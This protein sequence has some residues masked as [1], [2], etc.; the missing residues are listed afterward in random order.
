MT[1]NNTTINLLD[2][3]QN[4][5]AENLVNHLRPF[6]TET[7]G[8]GKSIL[9]FVRTTKNRLITSGQLQNPKVLSDAEISETDNTKL[10]HII[11]ICDRRIERKHYTFITFDLESIKIQHEAELNNI[12]FVRFLSDGLI[13]EIEISDN[14]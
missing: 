4:T 12:Y 5:K 11:T 14:N 2:F 13:Y 7:D 9:Y 1:V 3:Y 8:K 6:T 10:E